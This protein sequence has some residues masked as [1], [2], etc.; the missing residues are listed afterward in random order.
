M[1]RVK[2]LSKEFGTVD[3]GNAAVLA[4]SD[5][6]FEVRDNEFVTVIGPS[7]CGKTTL[8]R[9]IAGL[10][11][12]QQGEVRIDSRPVTGPGP[13]RAVVFQ[14]FALMPWADVL[15]NVTFGLEVRGVA[16]GESESRARE[17]IKRVGLEGF[18]RR[19]PKE[20]SGGMQQRVG[21][22]R[23]LAVNPQILLM[24]EPF[25]AL[26]EQTR[27]LLQEQ[28]LQLWERERK[29]V[30]FITHSME[31]AVMLGDR[32]MLMTPRPGKVK[33]MIEVPLKRPRSRDVE[34]SP[35]FVEIKE[36]LWENL[37]AMQTVQ[38]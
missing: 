23:A 21:L 32:V 29:T 33:E 6:D 27:R 3:N 16:K 20:L 19:L 17:L 35:A 25:G 7:G 24:D 15:G 11:P 36:Y 26:D 37:R 5:I 22:A 18:E 30:V 14:N 12:Y 28:L 9:I 10:I 4:L 1:I 31:E 13:E 34:K 2:A 38:P 8:L